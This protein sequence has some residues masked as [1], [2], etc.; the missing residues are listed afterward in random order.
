MSE[1]KG[2]K[3]TTYRGVEIYVSQY[4]QFSAESG[5]RKFKSEKLE[6]IQNSI[7]KF[8]EAEKARSPIDL[9]AYVELGDLHRGRKLVEVTV[10]KVHS[11][12]GKLMVTGD[13]EELR[14]VVDSKVS[15]KGN[16]TIG[17]WD[18]WVLK[19]DPAVKR[20]YDQMAAE[21]IRLRRLMDDCEKKLEKL[22]RDHGQRFHEISGYHRT[23]QVIINAENKLREFLSP[24]SGSDSES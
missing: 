12:Q 24:E 13:R 5:E 19:H 17:Q 18:V 15:A 8:L 22:R 2:V 3:V 14:K 23:E 6:N 10:R 7:E 9:P 20:S 16:L 21:V 1:E 4:G 11:S